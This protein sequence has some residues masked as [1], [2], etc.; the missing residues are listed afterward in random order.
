MKKSVGSWSLESLSTLSR[1][2]LEGLLDICVLQLYSL[3]D[4]FW[5]GGPQRGFSPS[6]LV[7][8]LI[9]HCCV[10]LC[11]YL[12]SLTPGALHLLFIPYSYALV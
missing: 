9:T 7:F 8:F 10:I 5:L 12:S 3:V 4:R 1:L 6:A 11:L 2:G